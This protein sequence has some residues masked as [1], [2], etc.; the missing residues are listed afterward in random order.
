M[1]ELNVG[2]SDAGVWER[3]RPELD[4][5]LS[6]LPTRDREIIL[7]R[8]FQ[9]Q[10]VA[11]IAHHLGVSEAAAYKRVER[12]LERL[13][14]TLLKRGLGSTAAALSIG[15]N[16]EAALAAPAGLAAQTA[17]AVSANAITTSS[18]QF[19]CMMTSTKSL[20]AAGVV[21]LGLFGT[22]AD[23]HNEADRAHALFETL[24][25]QQALLTAQIAESEKHYHATQSELNGTRERADK[26]AREKSRV[27]QREQTAMRNGADNT[28]QE[29][30]TQSGPLDLNSLYMTDPIFQSLYLQAFEYSLRLT[31]AQM[32][33][34]YNLT[35]EQIRQFE[36]A[37]I[38][39]HRAAFDIAEAAK[40]QSVTLTDP[41]LVGK[42]G[43]E[44]ALTLQKALTDILG[45]DN[46]KIFGSYFAGLESNAIVSKLAG[47]LHSTSHPLSSSQG[48]SLFAALQTS[49]SG[50][51][52]KGIIAKQRY[53]NSEQ[54]LLSARNILST[55]QLGVFS[56]VLRADELRRQS[57]ERS[58]Q[59]ITEAAHA[60]VTPPRQ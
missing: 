47:Y 42:L 21:A 46:L 41:R 37:M 8:Y 9:A 48:E 13:R 59:L 25:R 45:P 40:A 49:M 23:Q 58:Q 29:S 38:E 35:P 3:I 31:Y 33:A 24:T 36:A 60:T 19:L 52:A 6:T 11:F 20:A 26:L 16:S 53:P 30:P 5:A 10:P 44:I 55:D 2:E 51:E 56:E 27:N 43:P 28:V 4:S 54:V 1:N 7:F 50:Y 22:A 57:H 34:K 18:F 32:Y 14:G 15:L 39:Y 12:A 17:A